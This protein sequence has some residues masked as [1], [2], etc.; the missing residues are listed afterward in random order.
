MPWNVDGVSGEDRFVALHYNPPAAALIAQFERKTGVGYPVG[1]IYVKRPSDEQYWKAFAG[2]DTTTAVDV[3]TA[4]RAPLLFFQVLVVSKTP[5]AGDPKAKAG[6]GMNWSH[7]G[8]IDLS[9]GEQSVVVDAKRFRER[10]DGAWVSRLIS[11][12]E[13]GKSILCK[14]AVHKSAPNARIG[15]SVCR[16]HLETLDFDVLA[17]LSTTFF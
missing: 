17:A 3:A 10:H 9:T 1:S 6:I 8:R 2:D 14:I 11:A 16:L 4:S 7:V 12:S 5:K 13:D 15:Y